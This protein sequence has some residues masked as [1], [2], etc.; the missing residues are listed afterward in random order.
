M[1]T[2]IQLREPIQNGSETVS[3]LVFRAPRAKDFRSMPL[4]MKI[5]GDLLGLAGKLCNQPDHII[6]DLCVADMQE[7]TT[8]VAGFMAGGQVTGKTA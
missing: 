8:L 7:V 1:P 6:G 2:T 4:D 3:E 5:W